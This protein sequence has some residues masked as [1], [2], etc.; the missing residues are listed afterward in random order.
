MKRKKTSKQDTSLI[1]RFGQLPAQKKRRLVLKS[2]VSLG[3]LGVA[4]GAIS[5][6]DQQKRELHD[7]TTIGAGKPMVVQIHDTSCPICRRLKSRAMSV[8]EKDDSIDF[9]IADIVTTEGRAF[10]EKYGVQKTTLL[11]FDAEGQHVDTVFG[12]QT[13]EEIEALIAKNF[14]QPA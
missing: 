5:G 8:L 1:E 13:L 3:V 2:V 6:Y 10:Q 9:R 7:L 11:F 14:N 12:L 4:A